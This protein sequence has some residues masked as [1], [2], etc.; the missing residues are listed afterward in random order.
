MCGRTIKTIPTKEH[1]KTML[2]NIIFYRKENHAKTVLSA[3]H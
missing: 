2:V 3:V 1:M